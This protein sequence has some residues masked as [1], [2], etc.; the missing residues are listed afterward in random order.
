MPVAMVTAY[1]SSN[2]N[3]GIGDDG[4]VTT[5]DES[6]VMVGDGGV[7][8]YTCCGLECLLLVLG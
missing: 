3:A 7:G 4:I 2:G 8:E 6:V 1:S 5:M